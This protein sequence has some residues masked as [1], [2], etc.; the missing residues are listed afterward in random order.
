M[1]VLCVQ[2]QLLAHLQPIMASTLDCYNSAATSGGDTDF[3]SQ[4]SGARVELAGVW[5]EQIQRLSQ[6]LVCTCR[7]M[8][9]C[10]VNEGGG[11]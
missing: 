8:P 11:V 9:A 3:R 5:K 1:C 10:S 7:I 2:G 4:F 6:I